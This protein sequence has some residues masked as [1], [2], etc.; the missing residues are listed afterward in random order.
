M[1]CKFPTDAAVR[2]PPAGTNSFI[3]QK[4]W[5]N[6]GCDVCHQ[7]STA[8][9]VDPKPVMWN[10]AT[11]KYDTIATTTELC[12][13]CHTD[14]IGGSKHKMTIG[15]PA[16]TGQIGLAVQRPSQCTDCHNPHSQKASC[17]T[18]HANV[19]T[20]KP[21]TG[22][23]PAHAK[24]SCSAC[25]DASGATVGWTA[26]KKQFA[27]T[28]VVS[29]PAGSSVEAYSSHILQR[30]VSCARCHYEKNPFNLS[31]IAAPA[32]GRPSATATPTK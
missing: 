20:A 30:T 29:N 17:D 16:H 6:I 9:V 11:G 5:K 8:G 32:T 15:G 18:C 26:D 14:S 19:M 4:D 28:H 23:I 12:E 24:V 13:G 1:A 2:K 10:Q 22:H 25:H 27:T 31:V 7:V 21:N 3:E